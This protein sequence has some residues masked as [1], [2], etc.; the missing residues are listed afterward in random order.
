MKEFHLRR[1]CDTNW[2]TLHEA[3]YKDALKEYY[4]REMM[5]GCGRIEIRDPSEGP[6]FKVYEVEVSY[7]FRYT[8]KLVDEEE[9]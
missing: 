9:P 2:T 5:D 1:E 4:Q 6:K 3:D 7:D 8:G